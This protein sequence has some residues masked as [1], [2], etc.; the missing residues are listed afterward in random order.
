MFITGGDKTPKQ[1]LKLRQGKDTYH[2]VTLASLIYNRCGHAVC[3]YADRFIFA[4]GSGY[5]FK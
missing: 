3:A 5:D 1:C 2:K 4:S